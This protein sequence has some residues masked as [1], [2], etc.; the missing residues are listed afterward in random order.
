MQKQERKRK[1]AL[2]N[3]FAQRSKKGGSLEAANSTMPISGFTRLMHC[4]PLQVSR[5]WMKGKLGL[6]DAW[7]RA[8]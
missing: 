2:I 8:V 4:S 1:K 7:T 3:T 5:A 6:V